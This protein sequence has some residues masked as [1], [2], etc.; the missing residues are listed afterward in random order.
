MIFLHIYVSTL[1][2]PGA[3]GSK[4]K[5]TDSVKLELWMVVNPCVGAGDRSLVLCKSKYS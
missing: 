1:Y 4:K 5:A 2:V 3:Q